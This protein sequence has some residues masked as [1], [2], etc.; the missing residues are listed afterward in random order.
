MPVFLSSC[1]TGSEGLEIRSLKT[2]SVLSMPSSK[3][4]HRLGHAGV[5]TTS[6]D[7][8]SGK[9]VARTRDGARDECGRY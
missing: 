1:V 3:W 8:G 9:T 5:D 6:T 7:M 2:R 4:I